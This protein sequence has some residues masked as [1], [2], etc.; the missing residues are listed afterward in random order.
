MHAAKAYI[1]DIIKHNT[2]MHAHEKLACVASVSVGLAG[3]KKVRE[4]GF[5]LFCPRQKWCEFLR[6]P[7]PPPSF[8]FWLSPHFSRGK[9][10]ESLSLLPNPTE[11]LATQA[12]YL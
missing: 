3:A 2:H 11:T 7:P 5:S 6:S 1:I 8:V 9:N 12:I 10:T 4:T